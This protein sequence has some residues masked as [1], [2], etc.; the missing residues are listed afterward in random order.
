MTRR[1][2]DPASLTRP[3]TEAQLQA[4]VI[5]CAEWL[6]WRCYHTTYSIGSDRGYPDLTLVNPRQGRVL[7]AELK[8]PRGRLSPAQAA[9]LAELTSAGQEA[10]LWSPVQWISGEIESVLRGG[11]YER[12]SVAHNAIF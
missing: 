9:W 10:Y 4:A 3:M 1:A 7:W 8:G 11:G 6:G 5:E 12:P 2:I